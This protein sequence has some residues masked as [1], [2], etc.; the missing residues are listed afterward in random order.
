MSAHPEITDAEWRV[1]H[2]VWQLENERAEPTSREIIVRL[3][4]RI[5]WTDGTVKTLLH[6]LVEKG[7]LDFQRKGN[8]YL[9]RSNLSEN[10]SVD[11]LCGQLLHSVFEGQPIPMLRYLIH[12][13]RLSGREVDQLRDTL[14]EL[15]QSLPP[16]APR[17]VE[18]ESRDAA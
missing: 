17:V 2:E 4:D 15:R 8:R 7:V 16:Q 11:Q 6:R 13:C 10:Q 18:T 5:D 14:K 9:Y 1:M 3:R 12:S